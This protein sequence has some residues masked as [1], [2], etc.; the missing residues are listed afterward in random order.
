MN[1]CPDCGV[2]LDEPGAYCQVCGAP[3]FEEVGAESKTAEPALGHQGVVERSIT[4]FTLRVAREAW[5]LLR[6]FTV[7]LAWGGPFLSLVFL[8]TSSEVAMYPMSARML[9]PIQA[10]LFLVI[11][12]FA[13]TGIVVV[14]WLSKRETRL[15]VA[16]VPVL[17]T[18]GLMAAVYVPSLFTGDTPLPDWFNALLFGLGFIGT[19]V[20]ALLG[21]LVTAASLW[22]RL[23]WG[24]LVWLPGWALV[25]RLLWL[26]SNNSAADNLGA[27]FLAVVAMSALWAAS[28]LASTLAFLLTGFL[29]LR[30]IQKQTKLRT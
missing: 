27:G 9:A 14:A 23:W 18:V 4:P 3:L 21:A 2:K 22:R 20:L 13:I 10:R 12:F 16:S 11:P 29:G 6:L 19:P 25:A 17:L 24:T 1:Y 15:S 8:D 7:G 5:R 26:G 30:T 28:L